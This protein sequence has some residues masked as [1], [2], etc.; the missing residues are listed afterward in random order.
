MPTEARAATVQIPARS[1]S[2]NTFLRTGEVDA[3]ALDRICE[4]RG[5][6]VHFQPIIRLDSG[7][8]L[9][10]EALSRP[11]LDGPFTNATDL[12]AAA[13][14]HGMLTALEIACCERAVAKF[15]SAGLRG[16]LL[17]NMSPESIIDAQFFSG[18]RFDFLRHPGLEAGRVVVE[19]AE[20]HKDTNLERLCEAVM[21]FR[22]LGADIALNDLGRGF[23]SLWLW[24]ELKPGLVKIGPH[25]VQGVHRNAIKA[26]FI[27]SVQQIAEASGSGLVAEGIAD[28]ADF[29]ALREMGVVYG[30]GHFIARPSPVPGAL[31]GE[32]VEVIR[33]R[34]LS[35]L[36]EVLRLPLGRGATGDRLLLHAQP[37]TPDTSNEAVFHAFESAPG[38]PALAVVE[39]GVPAGLISRSGFL[40]AYSRTD[41]RRDPCA[42]LM[43]RE[44]LCLERS[45]SIQEISERLI[46]AE[47]PRLEAFILTD[48]GRYAGIGTG[49]DLIREILL[50]QVESARYAN[51]L[52][53]LPGNVPIDENIG[54]LI[55]ARTPFVAAYCDLNHFK[56]FNDAYG[57]RRGDEM[58]KLAARVL[59]EACDP[60][61]D[62]IGHI[63]GDDFILLF[64]SQ[65]WKKRCGRAL[66]RFAELCAPL[67][68]EED[69]QRGTLL[70]EDRSG[71]PVHSPLVTLAIGLVPV[72]PG[73]CESHLQVAEAAAEAKK[74][75]KR[76]GGN[77]LFVER[78]RQGAEAALFS[79]SD[80]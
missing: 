52:T 34:G 44:P 46:R 42:G 31:K 70:G 29:A 63:G 26:Q 16:K 61:Q 78:R 68:D 80:E 41:L 5:V 20:Q 18:A 37:V 51:P 35:A 11:P 30:Q 40:E 12:F 69:R 79:S 66:Q 3:E 24:S 22:A 75:A 21:V 39:G 56:P 4:H 17:L 7:D 33:S 23:S 32:V 15:V 74:Q 47:L 25:F 36:P 13:S 72:G 59:G 77:A 38:L 6:E 49:Q 19:L 71:N 60:R 2:S 73:C 45:L 28:K 48:D 57:Y 43:D 55:A 50:L 62:F 8:V 1:T 65:D 58:I 54:A 64:R 9:G 53:L 67:F 27:R 76:I 14:K 10:Y